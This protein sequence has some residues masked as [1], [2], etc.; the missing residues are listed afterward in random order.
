MFSTEKTTGVLIRELVNE[1]D[2][3]KENIQYYIN[4]E[5]S[6]SFILQKSV[7]YAFYDDANFGK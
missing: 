1:C 4:V 7:L 6:E 2:Q 3:E 5:S